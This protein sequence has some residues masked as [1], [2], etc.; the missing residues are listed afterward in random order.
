MPA[1]CSPSMLLAQADT[2]VTMLALRWLYHAVLGCGCEVLVL[3]AATSCRFVLFRVA[4]CV[5]G[6]WCIRVQRNSNFRHG[7]FCGSHSVSNVLCHDHHHEMTRISPVSSTAAV[8]SIHSN[9]QSAI[10]S[11][12]KKA[13]GHHLRQIC[14]QNACMRQSSSSIYYAGVVFVL[15]RPS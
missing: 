4:C 10:S 3:H 14:F 9:Q 12:K 13:F 7:K 2:T 6:C 1:S 5:V 11:S 8:H 15:S